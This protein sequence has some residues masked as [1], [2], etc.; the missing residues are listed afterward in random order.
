MIAHL[1]P[2]LMI[3]FGK[4]AGKTVA[5][6]REVDP[7]YVSWLRRQRNKIDLTRYRHRAEQWGVQRPGLFGGDVRAIQKG[8]LQ[9][10]KR[11]STRGKQPMVKR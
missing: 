3:H 9:Y 5:Q 1:H 4:Y 11:S 8:E 2:S 6:I 10:G 7:R